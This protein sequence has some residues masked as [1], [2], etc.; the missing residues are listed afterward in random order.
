MKRVLLA[1]V[2]VLFV[3][4]VGSAQQFTYYFPQVAIGGGWVTTIFV[5]NAIT[6]QTGIATIIFTQSDGT[7]YKTTWVDEMGNDVTK[8]GNSIAVR[9]AGGETRKFTSVGDIPFSMGFATVYSNSS[10]VLGNAVITAFDG[11]GN[12]VAEAGEPMAIPLLKQALFV[13][14]MHGVTMGVAIANPN[15]I[16]LPVH[17]ELIADTGQLIGSTD[18]NVGSTQQAA[19]FLTDLFPDM[20]AMIGRLQFS[21]TNPTSSIGFRFN[22][23]IIPFATIAPIAVSN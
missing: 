20:P 11:D 21:S 3:S 4:A 18:I 5:T 19:F 7:P 23:R 14:T 12:V 22:A 2:F 9:L 16:S 13:D 1:I 10:A 6:S 17:L 8:G 15:E